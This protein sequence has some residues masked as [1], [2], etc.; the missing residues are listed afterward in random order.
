MQIPHCRAPKWPAE[1]SESRFASRIQRDDWAGCAVALLGMPDD[2]GVGL[3]GGRLGAAEGPSAFRSALSRY[4]GN[5]VAIEWPGVFDAGDVEP[6]GSLEETHDRVSEA[7]AAIIKAGM[8]PVGIGGGHDL[9]YAFV[10][11]AL[12]GSTDPGGIYL[13]AHLDV[14]AE[15]GSG[16]PFRKLVEDVGVKE[17]HVLGLD[18][19]A[20]TDEHLRWFA[21]NG[22][23]VDALEVDADWPERDMF[24]SIDLD[25]VDQSAAPGVSAMNPCGWS[26]ARTA[27]WAWAAGAC[28][29]V[30]CFD[31]M[32]LSP[33][34][35]ESARTARLAARLFLEF[36][37]GFSER[38][39]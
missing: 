6:G 29:R 5:R 39:S 28:P 19:F 25:V 11:G 20:N 15:R 10:R 34:H 38:P 22:G 24:F 9:T 30:K 27:G 26:P 4:G 7:S 16:M 21:A 36:L 12:R 2:E 33:P 37:H 8:I 18:R 35:D 14:R 13:D 31:L 23:R 17:L 32:E 1:I 3:N